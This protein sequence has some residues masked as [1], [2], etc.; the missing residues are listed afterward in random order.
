VPTS[1]D[2]LLKKQEETQKLREQLANEE[3]K[4]HLT[5]NDLA[6]DVTATQLDAEQSRLK[7]QIA[8]LKARNT[9]KA[10]KD[11]AAAAIDPVGTLE[12]VE[13]ARLNAGAVEAPANP[14]E[15]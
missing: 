2:E 1:D 11:G 15:K 7:A 4:L 3:R 6:N 14:K 12:R 9:A 8:D 5:E 13:N 10:V